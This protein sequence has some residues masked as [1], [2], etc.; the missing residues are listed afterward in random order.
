MADLRFYILFNGIS[1][2]SGRE[3]DVNERLFAVE[4][5]LWLKRSSP[6]VGLKPMT[7]R[8]VGQRLTHW[9]TGAPVIK[10]KSNDN[11]STLKCI[12]IGTPNTTTFPFVRNGKWPNVSAHYN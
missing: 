3:V 2:I 10:Q 7:A 11:V 9:A 8:S 4:S 12:S 6:Q 5:L 1:V